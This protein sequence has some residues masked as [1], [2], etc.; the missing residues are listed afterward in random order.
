MGQSWETIVVVGRISQLDTHIAIFQPTKPFESFTERRE[1][2]LPQ[3]I[4]LHA[5][6]Q[7]TDAPHLLRLLR[8]RNK[9]PRCRRTAKKM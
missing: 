5:M 1:P 6:H 8:A 2:L 4:S 3:W 9:W 7:D